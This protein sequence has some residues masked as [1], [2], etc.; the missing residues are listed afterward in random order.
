MK[1]EG[2]AGFVGIIA[3]AAL[4]LYL[5]AAPLVA[6]GLIELWEALR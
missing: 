6:D 2:L 1:A 4:C 3:L 5:F